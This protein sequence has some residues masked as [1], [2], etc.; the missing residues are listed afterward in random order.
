MFTNVLTDYITGF[1]FR[2]KRTVISSSGML[3]LAAFAV[4][5][6][7][8]FTF[9]SRYTSEFYFIGLI[10][11]AAALL[12]SA[13][14][15][16]RLDKVMFLCPSDSKSRKRYF[17]YSYLLRTCFCVLLRIILNIIV[18]GAD[19]T[20]TLENYL[21]FSDLLFIFAVNL[22]LSPGTASTEAGAKKKLPAFYRFFRTALI[23]CELIKLVMLII[24]FRGTL[25]FLYSVIIYSIFYYVILP[26]GAVLSLVILIKYFRSVMKHSTEYEEGI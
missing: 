17:I 3:F 15:G 23:V 21:M 11:C 4:L 2:L 25:G 10:P 18:Y 22:Y 24:L 16:G 26:L 19:R 14:Y 13:M 8:P 7:L 5:C 9:P 20:F 1:L 12:L 6:I